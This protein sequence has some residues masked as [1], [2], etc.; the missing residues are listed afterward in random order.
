LGKKE[1]IKL[2]PA[3]DNVLFVA[4]EMN[5]ANTIN[6]TIIAFPCIGYLSKSVKE[7]ERYE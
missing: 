7:F 4:T 6:N 2:L 3:G 1:T 5:E